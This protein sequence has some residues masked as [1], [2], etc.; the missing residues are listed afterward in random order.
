MLGYSEDRILPVPFLAPSYAL[1]MLLD[2]KNLESQISHTI[3][4][5]F[6]STI[7]FRTHQ[8]F[9]NFFKRWKKSLLC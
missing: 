7:Y 5:Q 8:S 2:L 9:I 4:P 1:Y 3:F 6:L